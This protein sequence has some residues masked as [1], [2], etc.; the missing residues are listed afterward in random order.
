VPCDADRLGAGQVVVDLVYEPIETP[1]LA[2]ARA[3]GAVVHDGLGMLL[4]QA[5]RAF[6]LWTGVDA[7]LGS[8]AEA[9]R[10]VL[11]DR[12]ATR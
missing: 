12:P 9:A 4:H 8:M 3:R 1:L 6:T 11:D 10:R 5:A 7:P 2:A